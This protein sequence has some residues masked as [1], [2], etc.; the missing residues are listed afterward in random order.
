M[1][2]TVVQ[3]FNTLKLLKVVDPIPTCICVLG[4]KQVPTA[5]SNAPILAGC[6]TRST[7]FWYCLLGN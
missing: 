2:P 3:Y 4:G 1:L 7:Q 6:P 5:T